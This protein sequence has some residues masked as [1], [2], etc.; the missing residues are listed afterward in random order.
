MNH[1]VRKEVFPHELIGEEIEVVDS[2]NKINAGIRGKVI[3]ETRETIKVLQEGGKE[4]VLMKKIIVFKL[5]KSG[6]IIFGENI[7]KQYGR[8][9]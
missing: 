4:A 8:Q 2:K 7:A 6:K 1:M 9:A 5:V 3:D